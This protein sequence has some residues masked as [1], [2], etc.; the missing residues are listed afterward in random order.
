MDSDATMQ[1]QTN[2]SR[3][4]IEARLAQLRTLA[5]TSQ[6]TE[7]EALL[8]GIEGKGRAEMEQRIMGCLNLLGGSDDYAYLIDQLDMLT[9]NLQNL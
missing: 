7:V 5:H 6:L 4:E 8:T 1:F 3:A 2:L 9:L